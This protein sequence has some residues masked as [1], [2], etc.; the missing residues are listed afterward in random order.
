MFASQYL[1]RPI[2]SRRVRHVSRVNT[3]RTMLTTT[4]QLDRPFA[5]WRP[6]Y[7][8]LQRR[9]SDG[10]RASGWLMHRKTKN[11][12][13]EYRRLTEDELEALGDIEAW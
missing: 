7:F 1:N 6:C 3:G 5:G 8:F 12:Q 13:T 9:L 11:G 2:P 10:A 4:S